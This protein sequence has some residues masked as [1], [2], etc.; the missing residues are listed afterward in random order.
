MD[1]GQSLHFLRELLVR[2]QPLAIQPGDRALLDHGKAALVELFA[3]MQIPTPTPEVLQGWREYADQLRAQAQP[4]QP[5]SVDYRGQH[6]TTPTPVK[7]SA[8]P[9]N[10]PWEAFVGVAEDVSVKCAELVSK[11][12]SQQH[13]ALS[14]SE[15]ANAMKTWMI[16]AKRVTPKME[17][18]LTNMLDGVVYRMTPRATPKYAGTS[19]AAEPREASRDGGGDYEEDIPY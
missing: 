18:A 15:K 5:T 3:A 13:Y 4:A 8:Q 16:Q 14:L 1:A 7:P 9:S 6:A 10:T 17:N 2:F 11:D 12:P 19:R